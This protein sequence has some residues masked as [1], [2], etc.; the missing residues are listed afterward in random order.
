MSRSGPAAACSCRHTLL[1][2]GCLRLL[3]APLLRHPQPPQ[4]PPLASRS[5]T[6]LFRQHLLGRP[7][8][9]ARL[10]K[11]LDQQQAVLYVCGDGLN[12]AS[13]VNTAVREVRDPT[14]WTILQ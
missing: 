12:M 9:K 10:W 11:L 6:P 8:D 4:P 5:Q 14:T 2:T 13:D 3:S 7:A 1:Q